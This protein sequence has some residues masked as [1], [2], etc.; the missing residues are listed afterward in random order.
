MNKNPKE[1]KRRIKNQEKEDTNSSS[2]DEDI[3]DND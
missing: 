3:S 2:A 1:L